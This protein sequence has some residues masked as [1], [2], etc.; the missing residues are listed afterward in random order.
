[1]YLERLKK[2]INKIEQYYNDLSWNTKEKLNE[3]ADKYEILI[4]LFDDTEELEQILK[5]FT[6]ELE[7]AIKNEIKEMHYA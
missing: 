5:G 6:D 7:N 1:M 2:Q 4:E 3:I